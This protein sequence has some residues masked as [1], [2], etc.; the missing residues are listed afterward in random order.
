M[1]FYF[2]LFFKTGPHV[3]QD[4]PELT[5]YVPE[6]VLE[7]LT[8]FYISSAGIKA[9]AIVPRGRVGKVRM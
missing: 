3:A 9:C 2:V 7:P 8:C 5:M 6:D 4:S 1:C